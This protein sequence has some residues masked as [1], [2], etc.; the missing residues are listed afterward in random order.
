MDVLSL[1][2][3]HTR[4]HTHTRVHTKIRQTYQRVAGAGH[5]D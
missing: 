4:T 3:I 1:T 5:G 2:H